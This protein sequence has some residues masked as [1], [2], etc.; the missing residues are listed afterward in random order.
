MA[1]PNLKIARTPVEDA[2]IEAFRTQAGTGEAKGWASEMRA[3]AAESFAALGLP[4]RRMET[5][6]WT[7][8]RQSL[9]DILPL[10]Q[11]AEATPAALADI[12][13]YKAVFVNGHFVADQSRMPGGVEVARVSEMLNG[14]REGLAGRIG[15]LGE[16]GEESP[17]ALNT[18]FM[19]DGV[20]LRVPAGTKLD[21]TLHIAHRFTGEAAAVYARNVIVLEDGAEAE[22]AESF[23]GE[24]GYAANH[25]TEAH[26]GD[27]AT[28]HHRTLQDE[29]TE[30]VHLNALLVSLGAHAVLN[31]FVL[32]VGARL[33]RHQIGVRIAGEH[34]EL[35]LSGASLLR[36]RQHADV[37]LVVEHG[38]PHGTSRETFATVLEDRSRGVFQGKIIVPPKSQKTDGEMM[39]RALFLSDEAEF[40][41]K[42]ELEIFADDVLCAHGATA[43]QIDPDHLFYLMARG[44]SRKDAESLLVAGFIE[45]A[46]SAIETEDLHDAF[47]TRAQAWLAERR[48]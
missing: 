18:A 14:E 47:S 21:R 39:S 29:G 5:W 20:V 44:I 15:E 36:G 48:S 22:V 45:E 9:Q 31:H 8:V 12:D 26:V 2:L 1:S 33:A 35:N 32:H 25:V 11:P 40:D 28:L 24:G 3:A 30:A 4:H 7:D 10:A 19:T 6:K 38:A 43:G 23:E 17:M 42:P 13:G 41:A 34:A 37:S 16:V 46:V 27:N